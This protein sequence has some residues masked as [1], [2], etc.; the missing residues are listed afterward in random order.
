MFRR[1]QDKKKYTFARFLGDLGSAAA[2]AAIGSIVWTVD[3][4]S[5]AVN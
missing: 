4:I 3:K 2:A 5:D 1:K